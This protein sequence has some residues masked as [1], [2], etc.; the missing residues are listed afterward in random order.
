M[1]APKTIV[2]FR[3]GIGNFIMMT[4]AIRA[5][6]AL[7]ASGKVDICLADDWKDSRMPAVR[8]IAEKWDLVDS[9]ITYPREPFKHDYDLY[10]YVHHT[11]GSVALNYFIEKGKALWHLQSW[12]EMHE[13]DYYMEHVRK[14]G[15]KL[16]CPD[17]FVPIA[18]EP[19]IIKGH[20]Q[21]VIGLG[22]GAFVS[23]M[24]DKKRWPHFNHLAK[25][26]KR[27]FNVK[28]ALIGSSKELAEVDRDLVDYDCI[29]KLTI[30]QTAKMISQLD[31]F[32]TTDSGNMHIADALKVPMIALFGATY[33][34]KNR[35]VSREAIVLRAGYPCQPC[36]GK[37]K[38]NTCT[39]YRC[40]EDLSV[41]DVMHLVRKKM[42]YA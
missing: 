38:F 18:H 13:I 12:G 41:G 10:F 40:M 20:E 27:Y 30:T 5:L 39:K 25:T 36:Q 42:A 3:N 7:D 37:E 2:Y 19:T 29:D 32:I 16:L 15:S 14:L 1:S 31:L 26:L 17:Q 22:N 24:W 21:P 34:S 6:A 11:E 33:L 4:P 35:P 9:V 23:K 8:E 28:I